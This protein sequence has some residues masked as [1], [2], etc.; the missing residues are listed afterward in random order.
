MRLIG[1][2]AVVALLLATTAA[3]ARPSGLRSDSASTR[4]KTA[5]RMRDK[6]PLAPHL[7]AQLITAAEVEGDRKAYVEMLLTLGQTGAMEARPLIDRHILSVD[8]W[9]RKHARRALREWLVANRLL[10]EDD[11]LPEPPHRLYGPPPVLPPTA[12]A[13]HSLQ[14][15]AARTP[16][17]PMYVPPHGVAW[18][19]VYGDDAESLAP[20]FRLERSLLKPLW[21]T[22]VSVAGSGYIVAAIGAAILVG[23]G[24]EG[25]EA[26]FVPVVGPWI[27]MAN[28][29]SAFHAVTGVLQGTGL[30]LTILGLTIEREYAVR[31]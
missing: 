1:A 8:K 30:L 2:A 15:L 29:P 4:R 21:I 26:S 25:H 24:V 22:G 7:V 19:A 18:A 10:H 27:A 13:A 17:S 28:R 6:I 12:P 16:L 9:L 11:D 23:D 3:E 14:G 31:F 5:M 20:G